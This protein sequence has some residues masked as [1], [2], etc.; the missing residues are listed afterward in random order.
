MT[1]R[2]DTE[3]SR[4]F[5]IATPNARF[6]DMGTEFGVAVEAKGR[7]AVAVFAGKVNAEA[8]KADGGWTA[9]ISLEEG[10]AGVY[11]QAK[12]TRQVCKRSDFPTLQPITP[13]PS[14]Y[15]RWLEASRELQ[16]RRDL[17]AYYDFQPDPNNSKV[18]LNR[19]ASGAKYNGEIQNA[20]FVDGRFGEKCLGIH[21]C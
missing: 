18:L 2:A 20:A 4:Q 8:K 11:E 16:S 14:S 17:L 6:V 3:Q 21:G 7:A 12:F 5:T 1:A 10:Q 13:P 15:Q 9:Q 19:S